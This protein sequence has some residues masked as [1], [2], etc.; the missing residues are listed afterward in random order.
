[1]GA[2]PR[3]RAVQDQPESITATINGQVVSWK[4]PFY[5]PAAT[6]APAPTPAPANN[7]QPEYITATINGQVVSW[8]NPNFTP[9]G[10]S[11]PAP[12]PPPQQPQQGSG[13]NSQG[14]SDYGRIAYYNADQQQARGLT[15][16]GNYGGAGSGVWDK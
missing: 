4:N 2:G 13:T 3:K 15:F 12:T 1:M 8:K 9:A 7:G 6:Q 5:T 14:G 11:G 10:G 16:L